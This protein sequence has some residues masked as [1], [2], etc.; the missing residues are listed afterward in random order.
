MAAAMC[1]TP[2]K[3]L[4]RAVT[5]AY[6]AFSICIN[7]NMCTR[8]KQFERA[9]ASLLPLLL[10][11]LLLLPLPLL[12]LLPPPHPCRLLPTLEPKRNSGPV[13]GGLSR[14]GCPSP[15][16]GASSGRVNLQVGA[17]KSANVSSRHL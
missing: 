15:N 1:S 14:C 2:K 7:V 4:N 17:V 16:T 3:A 6:A 10:L 9:P 13:R 8:T 12:L 11:L 5:A